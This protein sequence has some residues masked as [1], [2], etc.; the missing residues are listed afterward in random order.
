MCVM[1][2][3]RVGGDVSGNPV[4][5]YEYAECKGLPAR[6][7]VGVSC[8]VQTACGGVCGSVC[9]KSECDLEYLYDKSHTHASGQCEQSSEL[10]ARI[11]YKESQSLKQEYSMK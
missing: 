7:S 4:G 2:A 6:M 10:K 8:D 1:D 3:G 11:Y 5:G 9:D